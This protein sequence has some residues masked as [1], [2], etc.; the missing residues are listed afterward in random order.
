[1]LKP[2]YDL[3]V[4]RSGD[5]QEQIRAHRLGSRDFYQLVGSIFRVLLYGASK[6]LGQY[7]VWRSILDMGVEGYSGGRVA[8]GLCGY[9]A[10]G[11]EKRSP[12]LESYRRLC[13]PCLGS[14]L[15]LQKVSSE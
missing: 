7:G 12:P 11:N 13:L 6:S 4:V 2:V 14:V 8:Y 1:M 5:V 15:Y 10:D 9:R 3:G